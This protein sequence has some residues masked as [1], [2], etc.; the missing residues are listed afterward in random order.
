M[1]DT[2][3][4]PYEIYAVK[5]AWRDAT[6]NEH[7]IFKDPH[8]DPAMPMDY[9]VWAIVGKHKTYVLDSGFDRAEGEKRGRDFIR[10]PADGLRLIGIEAENIENLIVSHLHYDHIGT[11]NDFPKAKLYLQE[12]EMHYAVGRQMRHKSLRHSFVPDHLEG[13]IRA[14]YDDRL[15]F[16]DK[17]EEIAPGLS[18][19]HVGGHTVGLQVAR[20]WTRRGW[21]VMAVDAS[22]YYLN[23]EEV[24]PY[25]TVNHVGDMLD[26]YK[27]MLNLADSPKH[28]I[29]GHD[30][31]VMQRYPAPSKEMEGIVA[32]L[33]AD[34]LY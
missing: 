8:D 2:P 12:A 16:P 34:P 5:Y 10:Q 22:H 21:M 17:E 23:F 27:L 25:R 28:I 26:G 33:D 6:R 3:L 15:Y 9:F 7:L 24:Q 1:T 13:V 29:P 14:L 18:L 32:R 20:V 19:H 31:L 30:P 4:S 11:W